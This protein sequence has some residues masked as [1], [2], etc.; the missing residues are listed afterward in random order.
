MMISLD[1]AL[2]IVLENAHRLD[3]VSMN[4]EEARGAVLAQPIVALE[5]Q[6]A[7]ASSAMDGFA[8]RTADVKNAS[9][10]RPVRLP[11]S[12]TARAGQAEPV[13]VGKGTAV[14]IMT[15]A[16]VPE[17]A[18]A[19]V[20]WED[21]GEAESEIVVTRPLSAGKN[22]RKAAE[23]LKAGETVLKEGTL[24][25]PSVVALL[26]VLGYEDVQ[27]YPR[28]RVAVITTGDELVAVNDPKGPGK[29]RDS[30]APFLVAGL[31]EAGIGDIEIAA[32]VEDD[33][34]TLTSVLQRGLERADV[35]IVTGGVSVGDF[36][37]VKQILADL[38]VRQQFWG[39]NVKPGKPAYFGT[40]GGKL[41][42]GLP[43]NPVSVGV[44]FYELVR[45]ALLAMMGQKDG[46]LRRS[47]GRLTASIRKR[48]S[49]LE[50][51]RAS[52][53]EKDGTVTPLSKQDSHMLSGFAKAN[54][55]IRFPEDRQELEAGEEV[56]LDMLPEAA[57]KFF[58]TGAS[59]LSSPDAVTKR[60]AV[61]RVVAVSVSRKKGL[62][63]TNVSSA[64]LVEAWG[65]EGDVHAGEWHRQ[66]SLLA[67]ESIEKMRAKGLN[68]QPG[69][70]A[71]NITTE[72][73]ELPELHVGDRVRIG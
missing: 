22:I 24:V 6:P 19:V 36:D 17:G 59:Q 67:I 27:V 49:R 35:L 65:I 9:A 47:V 51:V 56:E 61:G 16:R 50:L 13:P 63:K 41:V 2:G 66:V 58:R 3:S 54:C 21:V 10:D 73:I 30:N 33:K 8:L 18:D 15:G 60:G 1:Q 11:V 64:R 25:T 23:E 44:L 5:D 7:F 57:Q 26:A 14:R 70:F 71:E 32:R 53:S 55:L 45:P 69:A 12:A 20:M 68:V 62:A 52:F 72:S 4:F 48:T 34:E 28:P 39:I 40:H 42:F 43:G 37:F 38:G 29:I 31:S 46:T